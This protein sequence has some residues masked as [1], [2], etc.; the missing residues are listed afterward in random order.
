MW[1][2][3]KFKRGVLSTVL[4]LGLLLTNFSPLGISAK[5][6]ENEQTAVVN[7]NRVK[8]QGGEQKAAVELKW[9]GSYLLSRT[10]VQG[11]KTIQSGGNEATGIINPNKDFRVNMKVKLPVAEG[12]A[13]RPYLKK[14]DFIRIPMIGKGVKVNGTSDLGKIDAK[15]LVDGAEQTVTQAFSAKVVADETTKTVYMVMTLLVDNKELKDAVDLTADIKMDFSVDQSGM[16]KDDKG[17]YIYSEEKKIYL[18]KFDNKFVVEK[19]GTI[20]YDKGNVDWTVKVEKIGD[21]GEKTSLAG[22]KFEDPIGK[23]GAYIP[24]TFTVYEAGADN[25]PGNKIFGD[26]GT[27]SSDFKQETGTTDAGNNNALTYVF[28]ANAPGKAIVKF[29]TSLNNNDDYSSLR[30]GFSKDNTAYLYQKEENGNKYSVKVAE[31]T[32]TVR[33]NGMWGVKYHGGYAQKNGIRDALLKDH[34]SDKGMTEDSFKEL[35]EAPVE[36][37]ATGNHKLQWNI[38]YDATDKNLTNV[39]IRD[40]FP[41][42]GNF[43]GIKLNFKKAMLRKWDV[44]KKAWMYWDD[45]AKNWSANKKEISAQPTDGIYEVGDLNTVVKLTIWSEVNNLKGLDRYLNVAK[46]TWGNGKKWLELT[47]SKDLGNTS[48]IKKAETEKAETKYIESNPEW[49]IYVNK[50]TVDQNKKNGIKTYVYDTVID[51][52]IGNKDEHY[53]IINDASQTNI[54]KRANFTLGNG[55]KEFDSGVKVADVVYKAGTAKMSY[56]DGSFKD[57]L[58]E[59]AL[60]VNPHNLYYNDG[61]GEKL[62]GKILEVTGFED[63]TKTAVKDRIQF[64]P[65]SFRTNILDADTLTG[66]SRR[67]NDSDLKYNEVMNLAYLYRVGKVGKDGKDGAEYGSFSDYW[68]R[69]NHRMIQKDALTSEAA[70]K[71]IAGGESSYTAA[72]AN[73]VVKDTSGAYAKDY[74]SVVFRL[75][76]NAENIKKLDTSKL[77]AFIKDSIDSKFKIVP[78]N[79]KY[80][81]LV[82]KGTPRTAFTGVGYTNDAYVIAEGSPVDANDIFTVNENVANGDKLDTTFTLK[83]LDA[84]YV[85]LL[86]AQIR[87][88]ENGDEKKIINSKGVVTNAAIVTLHDI[89]FD[90]T[91]GKDYSL[92]SS[93]SVDYDTRFLSKEYKVEQGGI[94]RWVIEY[95]PSIMDAA[96]KKEIEAAKDDSAADKKDITLYDILE[97]GLSVFSENG[98]PILGKGYYSLEWLTKT[99][100]AFHILIS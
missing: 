17:N 65:F 32:T 40:L 71:L 60:K 3:I 68:A 98:K 47:H 23:V 87:D 20:D 56:E 96:T 74:K 62:V 66:G 73:D 85:I 59:G 49:R 26:D 37:A 7:E 81:Y 35:D 1:K 77:E 83:K 48:I 21:I 2:K 38:V 8:A 28:P 39:K 91:K 100:T 34:L 36:D 67:G 86:R 42:A 10:V 5:E 51:T 95:N 72:N 90:G 75:S 97:N 76:V 46:V 70:G 84:P 14:N 61:K 31:D 44:D 57:L 78:L 11:D 27:A 79:D 12:K 50:D 24:K 30:N 80:N 82:F 25:T 43:S 13:S 88:G 64:Y 15:F 22:Y 33:W 58:N 54:E 18:G 53:K 99:E 6:S 55:K 4:V 69:Y 16:G 63:C 19:T 89:S 45:A 29:S 52:S 41:I 93:K 92:S 9:D 94:I